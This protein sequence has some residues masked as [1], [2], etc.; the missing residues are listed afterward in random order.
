VTDDNGNII[1][2]EDSRLQVC[3]HWDYW[4]LGLSVF[5]AHY[6]RSWRIDWGI[7]QPDITLMVGPLGITLRR[8]R[9]VTTELDGMRAAGLL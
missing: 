4:G 1:G 3:L 6:D 2:D 8:V 5:T 9:P 7:P